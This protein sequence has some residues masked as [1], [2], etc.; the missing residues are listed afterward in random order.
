VPFTYY[1]NPTIDSIYPRYGSKDGSTPIQV[2]GKNF[3]RFGD[4]S[5]CGFGSK[6]SVADVKNDT[7]LEC[8]TPF[9]D[10]VE[11]AM[12]FTLSFNGQ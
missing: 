6:T 2:F 7:Y 4:A 5:R 8:F 12:P 11:K 1:I 10:I 3:K 9:S